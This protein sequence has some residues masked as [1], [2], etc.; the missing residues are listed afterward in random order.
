MKVKRKHVVLASLVLALGTAVYVNWN[1]SQPPDVSTK[2]ELGKATYVNSNVVA[3][4]DE[5]RISSTGKL[6]KEQQNYFANARLSRDKIY[7]ETRAVAMEALSLSESDEDTKESAL[8]QLSQLEEILLNQNSV[9]NILM[10]KGF[11]DCVCT[12]SDGSASVIV[13]ESNLTDNSL[14]II[15]DAVAKVCS[16]PFENIS[17][18]TV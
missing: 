13:P 2:R 14:L 9:E 5:P 17:V 12:L 11:A 18:I 6:T 15:K 1:L 3:T 8:N 16:I 10:A 7:D 4:V